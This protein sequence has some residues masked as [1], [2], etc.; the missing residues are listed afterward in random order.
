VPAKVVAAILGHA[1]VDTTLNV[2]TQVLDGAA[3][4]AADR[5]GSELARIGQ[6]SGRA[7]ALIP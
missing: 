6:M 2:Y 4:E 1:K 3:R 7:R 5:V